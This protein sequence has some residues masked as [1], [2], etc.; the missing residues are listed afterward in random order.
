MQTTGKAG[1]YD[2]GVEL[3][4]DEGGEFNHPARLVMNAG[5]TDGNEHIFCKHDGNLEEGFEIVGRSSYV[6]DGFLITLRYIKVGSRFHLKAVHRVAGIG[7]HKIIGT[8]RHFLL[9]L[10]CCCFRASCSIARQ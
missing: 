7:V 6:F 1:G 9:Q 4:I 10:L 2:F 8:L 3:E 5:N